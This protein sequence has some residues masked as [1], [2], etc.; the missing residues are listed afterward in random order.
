MR[1]ERSEQDRERP[2]P[3]ATS[4]P[5]GVRERAMAG[6]DPERP[7]H[8]IVGGDGERLELAESVNSQKNQKAVGRR[9]AG[10]GL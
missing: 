10:L 3:D 2:R 9:Q 6:G 4:R 8:R 1:R 5:N 7:L